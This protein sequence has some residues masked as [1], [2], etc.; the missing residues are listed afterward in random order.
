MPEGELGW[1]G[2]MQEDGLLGGA[3]QDDDLLVASDVDPDVLSS[4]EDESSSMDEDSDTGEEGSAFEP[5]QD[6]LAPAPLIDQLDSAVATESMEIALPSPV[7]HVCGDCGRRLPNPASGVTTCLCGLCLPPAP[8]SPAAAESPAAA[9]AFDSAMPPTLRVP[10]PTGAV[11]EPGDSVPPPPPPPPPAAARA[12]RPSLSARAQPTGGV[13]RQ[14]KSPASAHGAGRRR[15][16]S[17][18]GGGGGGGGGGA[19]AQHSQQPQSQ[20]PPPPQQQQQQQQQKANRAA[21]IQRWYGTVSAKLGGL[22]RFVLNDAQLIYRR[23]LR[24]TER[25]GV[26]E[27]SLLLASLDHALHRHLFEYTRPAL[28]QATAGPGQPPKVQLAQLAAAA[29]VVARQNDETAAP[30]ASPVAH[31][32]AQLCEELLKSSRRDGKSSE[33]G[34]KSSAARN[35]LW[36]KAAVAAA[37]RAVLGGY[38]RDKEPL[39]FAAAI[40]LMIFERNTPFGKPKTAP[41]AAQVAEAAAIS[42][43]ALMRAYEEVRR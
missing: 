28:C 1:R 8:V 5:E 34:A 2:M 9:A 30:S 31:Y 41:N 3:M 26:G 21:A 11:P 18:V 35:A 29:L 43:D 19:G 17:E 15:R 39:A 25:Q 42:T 37:E 38:G 20:P 22:P 10:M 16:F 13:R 40:T 33:H 24:D 7:G 4:S 6:G 27:H 23:A 36:I 32:T 12:A 14:S